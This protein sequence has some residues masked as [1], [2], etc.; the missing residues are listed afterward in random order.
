MKFTIEEINSYFET[1][2][3]EADIAVSKGEVPVGAVVVCEK[4][5]KVIYSAH[6]LTETLKDPT[7]HAEVLA[8]RGA[9]SKVGDWRLNQHSLFVTLEP[10]PMCATT[11]I[12]SRI[13]ELYFGANDD[14]AGA[15]GSRVDL[16]WPNYLDHK[17][18]VYSN[19]Q[20]ERAT[21]LL[22]SFFADLRKQ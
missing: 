2:F 6:N 19:F 12:Q 7:A 13:S 15:C 20:A 5:K 18:H 3:L 1:A 17:I 11:I 21:T 8:I 22:K 4:S 10:C 9:S 14:R 16:L